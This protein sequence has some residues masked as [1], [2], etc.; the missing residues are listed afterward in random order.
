MSFE[1][2]STL[3]STTLLAYLDP[4]LGSAAFQILLASLLSAGF[5]LKSYFLQAKGLFDRI[6]KKVV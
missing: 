1:T 5:F 4:G 3:D 2:L 6:F